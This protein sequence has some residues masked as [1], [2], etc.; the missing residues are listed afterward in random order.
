MLYYQFSTLWLHFFLFYSIFKIPIF[1]LFFS[2]MGAFVQ[3]DRYGSILILLHGV[4]QFDQCH[5]LFVPAGKGENHFL[6]VFFSCWIITVYQP[7][8][9]VIKWTSQIFVGGMVLFSFFS[10][11][12]H[13]DILFWFLLLWFILNARKN[14]RLEGEE[15]GKDLEGAGEEKNDQNIFCEKINRI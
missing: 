12:C 7:H 15:D 10:S 4:I 5:L 3:R 9:K 14:T 1:I 6:F 8:S 2:L 13:T 11:F